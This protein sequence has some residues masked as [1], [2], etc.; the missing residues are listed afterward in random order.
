MQR[1]TPQTLP[2]AT[3]PRC[4]THDGR[5][6]EGY[7]LYFRCC[8]TDV[9]GVFQ[10]TGTMVELNTKKGLLLWRDVAHTLSSKQICFANCLERPHGNPLH[11]STQLSW[12]ARAVLRFQN[13]IRNKVTRRSRPVLEQRQN[14]RGRVHNRRCKQHGAFS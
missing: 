5:N 14:K 12:P 1:P 7:I 9:L 4:R 2:R 8:L 6:N 3:R 10:A 11:L 13:K